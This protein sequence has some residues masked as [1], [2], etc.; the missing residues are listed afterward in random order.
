MNS[1]RRAAS[2]V[3]FWLGGGSHLGR[4]VGTAADPPGVKARLF[5]W[6]RG[7]GLDFIGPEAGW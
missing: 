5:G 3:G 6:V 7:P 2:A 1:P 4:G